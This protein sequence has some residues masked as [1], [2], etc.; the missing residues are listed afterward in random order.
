MLQARRISG[1]NQATSNGAT[2]KI[3]G[4]SGASTSLFS[5]RACRHGINSATF[6]HQHS[7]ASA[8]RATHA[9]SHGAR[10]R[11]C[12]VADIVKQHQSA[13]I[14]PSARRG[15]REHHRRCAWNWLARW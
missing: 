14:K 9:S 4:I 5:A 13:S 1:G 12:C 15:A 10:A 8:L 2:L 6:S 3:D 7:T 11:A